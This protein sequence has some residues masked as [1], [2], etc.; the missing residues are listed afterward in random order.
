MFF[1]DVQQFKI[2][3]FIYMHY[4]IWID[5]AANKIKAIMKF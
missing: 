1:K 4:L 2:G 3:I 5:Q